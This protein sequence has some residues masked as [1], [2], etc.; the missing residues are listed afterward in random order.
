MQNSVIRLKS[1]ILTTPIFGLATPL[2]S[3]S[4]FCQDSSFSEVPHKGKLLLVP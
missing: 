4:E 2:N 1:N 3:S